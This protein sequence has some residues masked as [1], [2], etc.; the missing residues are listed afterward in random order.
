MHAVNKSD[1]MH[2]NMHKHGHSGF[3]RTWSVKLPENSWVA[4]FGHWLNPQAVNVDTCVLFWSSSNCAKIFEF[5]SICFCSCNWSCSIDNSCSNE[6]WSS[7][8]ASL[9]KLS[10]SVFTTFP[11]CAVLLIE[12]STKQRTIPIA[13]MF[14]FAS[15]LNSFEVFFNTL[16]PRKRLLK[17]RFSVQL[18][19]ISEYS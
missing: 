13:E 5:K 7:E 18:W 2:K 1:Y 17:S 9:S 16:A 4:L 15:R 19:Y 6:A 14:I 3:V 12:S 11:D 8:L 10:D